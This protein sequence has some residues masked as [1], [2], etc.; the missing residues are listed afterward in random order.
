MLQTC[1]IK[2][3]NLNLFDVLEICYHIEMGPH[4]RIYSGTSTARYIWSMGIC[5]AEK[6]NPIATTIA[7]HLQ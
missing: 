3:H 5:Y 4:T 2:H 7:R 1:S 6:R